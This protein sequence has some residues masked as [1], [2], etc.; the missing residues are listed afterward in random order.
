MMGIV[1]KIGLSFMAFSLAV[2]G[3]SPLAQARPGHGDRA[4]RNPPK[5]KDR[6]PPEKDKKKADRK[7]TALEKKK[8]EWA[9]GSQ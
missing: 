2:F 7:K 9:S 6:K 8:R 5:E 3:M 4:D 1:R